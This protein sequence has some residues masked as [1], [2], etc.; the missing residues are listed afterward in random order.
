MG[1]ADPRRPD[2]E[3]AWTLDRRLLDTVS[4]SSGTAVLF[5]SGRDARLVA[6]AHERFGVLLGRDATGVVNHDPWGLRARTP[7]HLSRERRWLRTA[8]GPGLLPLVEA[9]MVA[10]LDPRA[11]TWD[12]GAVR[13]ATPA[14]LL[15]PIWRPAVRWWVPEE[16]VQARYGD[17]LPRGWLAGYR[18]VTTDRSPRTLLPVALPPGA[19]A[20]S[21]ALLDAPRLPLLLSALAALPTDYLVRARGGGNNLSLY[22]I[23]QVPVP[24]P[25]VYDRPAPWD[26]RVT[27]ARWLTARLLAA[28]V[29]APP[30]AALAAEVGQP[31]LA[32]PAGR[33]AEVEQVE[34]V[35][36]VER[37][38]QD[39]ARARAEIDAAHA[40]L[41]GWT[42]SDL[43]HVLGTFDALRARERMAG[44]GFATRRRVLAAY[45]RLTGR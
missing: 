15:D 25:Q 23:E 8:P 39:R 9:K 35:E 45:A 42:R 41:L 31:A 14:E 26:P 10:L 44:Q 34:R 4:P 40:V 3:R 28:T 7:I 6:A 29:W 21:L 43:E 13:P 16:L 5:A 36:R 33:A 38:E 32:G 2:V 18:V 22:K 12:A 11:A 20:N 27:V 17:L 30:L 37:V 19:Y 1:S 24:P